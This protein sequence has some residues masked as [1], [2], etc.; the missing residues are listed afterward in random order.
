MVRAV[1]FDKG[2]VLHNL[3]YENGVGRVKTL[4][5]QYNN[6]KQ[7]IALLGLIITLERMGFMCSR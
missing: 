2:G 6:E 3:S 5:G 1:L 7:L 4:K